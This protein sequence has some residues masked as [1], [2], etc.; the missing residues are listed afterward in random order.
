MTLIAAALLPVL[1]Y[2]LFIYYKFD[3]CDREPFY[4]AFLCLFYG[5]LSAFP[6]I[7]WENSLMINIEAPFKKALYISFVTAA[8]PEELF[9]LVLLFFIIYNNPHF[10]TPCDGIFYSVFICM[11]FA[12]AEN[13]GYVL[14]PVL[15]GVKT[16]FF[17]SIFSVPCHGIF[18]TAMGYFF[19]LS[20][21]G[22]KTALITAFLVPL[23]LHGIYDLLLL[24]PLPH[25]TLIFMT[26]FAFLICLCIWFK[27]NITHK[28]IINDD[29]SPNNKNH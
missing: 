1:I 21:P 4:M 7:L 3:K 10:N 15:G 24:Y 27:Y 23:M 26:Y 18:A 13:S 17:R 20:K 6:I 12:G 19:T 2:L 8:L 9:K 11:G 5:A 16:A 14:H 29:F 25:N 22:R 28:Q